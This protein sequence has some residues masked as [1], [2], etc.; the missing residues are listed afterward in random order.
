MLSTAGPWRTIK[1]LPGTR[2]RAGQRFQRLVKMPNT[3]VNERHTAV[4]SMGECIQDVG[5]EHEGA[6]H[7]GMV[8]QRVV[9]RRMVMAA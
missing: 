2:L 7:L 1:P 3:G 5:I 6:I 4:V 9:Q 8:P